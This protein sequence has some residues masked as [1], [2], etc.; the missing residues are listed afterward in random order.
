MPDIYGLDCMYV[1][2]IQVRVDWIGSVKTDPC[3]RHGRKSREDRSDT[4]QNLG[5]GTPI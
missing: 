5:W 3:P 2:S 1:V 4:P